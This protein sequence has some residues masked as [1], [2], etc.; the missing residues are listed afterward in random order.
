MKWSSAEGHTAQH[1][2]DLEAYETWVKKDHSARHTMLSSMQNDL[3]GEYEDFPTAKQMWDQLKFDFGGTSTTRLRSLVLK[4]EV[5][6]KDPKHSM[7]EHLRRMSSMIRELKSAGNVL[8][9]EQQVLA[10]IRSLHD[11][12]VRTN[13][14][15]T[16]NESI[17]NFS[18]IS[19]HVEL[20]AERQEAT[21][22]ATL[23]AQGER[24]P[25]GKRMNNSQRDA[26]KAEK[27]SKRRRGKRAG[28]RDKSKMKC[29]NCVHKG[30]FG[31]ESTEMKKIREQQ[32]M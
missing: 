1:R 30:H 8:S 7:T 22:V 9:D 17:K 23:Y 19:R 16:H 5:Y 26:E 3:I 10:V 2:R 11:S 28:K 18:D 6:R 31:R 13:Q 14:I 29:Y 27:P 24:K 12:W 21:R 25:K 15:L 4:F 32:N 20:E